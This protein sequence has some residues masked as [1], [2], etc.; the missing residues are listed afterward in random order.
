MWTKPWYIYKKK[1]KHNK[2]KK[3]NV[4]HDNENAFNINNDYDVFFFF[5]PPRLDDKHSDIWYYCRRDGTR[6]DEEEE[7]RSRSDGQGASQAEPAE[8]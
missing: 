8:I 5:C 7:L 6:D 2:W 1:T 4:K 3:I